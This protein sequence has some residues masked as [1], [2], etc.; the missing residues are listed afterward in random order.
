[1]E[2]NTCSSF[3]SISWDAHNWIKREIWTTT[4]IFSYHFDDS[5]SWIWMDCRISLSWDKTRSNNIIFYRKSFKPNICLICCI[6]K[7][8][9]KSTKVYRRSNSIWEKYLSNYYILIFWYI[10][11]LLIDA[12]NSIIFICYIFFE[13]NIVEEKSNI[14]TYNSNNKYKW[15]IECEITLFRWKN[16]SFIYLHKIEL[17]IL[18]QA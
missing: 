4:I 18:Y 16:R 1:M 6:P 12:S 15:E 13:R 17:W 9:K 14:P 10:S 7:L 2:L 8:C 5:H 3:C 11:H